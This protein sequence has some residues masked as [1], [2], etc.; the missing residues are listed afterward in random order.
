MKKLFVMLS[1]LVVVKTFAI[2]KEAEA[3]IK[4]KC[5][6]VIKIDEI[7]DIKTGFLKSYKL[8]RVLYK[9]PF[10]N[11]GPKQGV[12]VFA[13]NKN[14]NECL[15]LSTEQNR[16]K[17]LNRFKDKIITLEDFQ[18]AVQLYLLFSKQTVVL[19]L[20]PRYME[21]FKRKH[22]KDPELRYILTSEGEKHW[23][24]EYS[25]GMGATIRRYRLK[26]TGIFEVETILD[27]Y[28]RGY[29]YR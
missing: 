19:K 13:V 27:I 25:A 17:L 29:G 21:K 26:Y 22:K 2:D 10:K 4:K 6:D 28:H 3:I 14:N 23:K 1:I 7:K 12:N 5:K 24:L 15:K 20:E 16:L 9:N 8:F 11:I 18:Y